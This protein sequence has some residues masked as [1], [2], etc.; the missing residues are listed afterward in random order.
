V[1]PSAATSGEQFILVTTTSKGLTYHL[2]ESYSTNS[3]I[4]LF[5]KSEKKEDFGD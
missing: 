4:D 1:I 3:G 5:E 2:I